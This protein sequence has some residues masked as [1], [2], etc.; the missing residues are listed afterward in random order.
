MN[1]EIWTYRNK[2]HM[3]S[4]SLSLWSLFTNSQII[5]TKNPHKT[6]PTWNIMFLLVSC[7]TKMWFSKKYETRWKYSIRLLTTMESKAHGLNWPG[8]VIWE[9]NIKMCGPQHNIARCEFRAQLSVS[10]YFFV[11]IRTS[12]WL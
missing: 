4:C 5:F 10:C 1:I 12:M 3:V 2:E 6:S 9:F 11:K 8:M 7:A